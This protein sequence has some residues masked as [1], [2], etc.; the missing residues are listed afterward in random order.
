M[1]YFVSCF[2]LSG[3]LFRRA[4]SISAGL[5]GAANRDERMTVGVWVGLLDARAE[6]NA[7]AVG[8][9]FVN[10]DSYVWL[11]SNSRSSSLVFLKTV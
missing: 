5:F 6:M 2:V 10:D 3:I 9:E 4:C 11:T 1:H 8:G 7:E